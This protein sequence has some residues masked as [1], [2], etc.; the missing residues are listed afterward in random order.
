MRIVGYYV[1]CRQYTSRRV[2]TTRVRNHQ[3]ICRNSRSHRVGFYV[4]LWNKPLTIFVHFIKYYRSACLKQPF[5]YRLRKYKTRDDK[6]PTV[7]SNTI[8]IPYTTSRYRDF[9]GCSQENNTC[10][11][12][13]CCTD[14]CRG[15]LIKQNVFLT[16]S[17]FLADFP[18]TYNS[19]LFNPSTRLC[20]ISP[21]SIHYNIP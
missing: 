2:T 4:P 11:S 3:P 21:T 13:D 9:N 20:S 7:M 15:P 10:L 18:R 17:L 12:D 14:N 19:I 16:G 1:S 5:K 6:T 8:L